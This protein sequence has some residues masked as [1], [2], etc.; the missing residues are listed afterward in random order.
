MLRN[1]GGIRGDGPLKGHK[2][3]AQWGAGALSYGQKTAYH[4]NDYSGKGKLKG[5][6]ERRQGSDASQGEGECDQ[7]KTGLTATT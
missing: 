5:R 2:R 1:R 3:P 4:T 7:K 6:E